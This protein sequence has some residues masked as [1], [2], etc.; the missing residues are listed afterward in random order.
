MANMK[1]ATAYTNKPTLAGTEQLQIVD[2]GTDKQ[3]TTASIA[4]LVTPGVA[5]NNTS[6]FTAN[7]SVLP[8]SATTSGTVTPNAATSNNFQYVANG[9]ITIANPSGL[10]K[11]MVLNFC[12]DQDGTGGHSITLG[13]LF[14]WPGGATPSWVTT[15]GSLNFFSAYYDG[16][17][18]RCGGG[19]GYIV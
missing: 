10:V 1:Y 6:Q 9:N 7:Q 18:L 13:S 12:V 14:F 15:A 3:C 16:T 2:S 4:A 11:G 17:Q 8:V 5:L 19:V